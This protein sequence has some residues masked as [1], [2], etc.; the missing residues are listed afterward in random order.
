MKLRPWA[1]NFFEVLNWIALAWAILFG[2]FFAIGWVQ[3]TQG[4]TGSQHSGSSAAFAAAFGAVVGV[5]AV[6]SNGVFPAALLWLLR[7]KWV[8]PAFNRE[9]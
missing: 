6:L 1:R 4:G 5:F 3:I 9:G 2:V 8:R 7:S